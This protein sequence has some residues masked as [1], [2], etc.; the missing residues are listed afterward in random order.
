MP[1]GE[2]GYQQNIQAMNNYHNEL[3]EHL[4]R[5]GSI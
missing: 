2:M 5:G 1:G 3:M 4:K